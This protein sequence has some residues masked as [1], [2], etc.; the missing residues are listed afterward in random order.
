MREHLLNLFITLIILSSVMGSSVMVLGQDKTGGSSNYDTTTPVGRWKTVDDTTGK[1]KSVV[2]LWEEEGKLYGKIERL[3]NPDPKDPDPRCVRCAGDLKNRHVIGLRIVWDLTQKRDQW[4]GGEI[5][6]PEN[7]KV[8]RCSM[9]VKDRGKKLRVRGFVGFSLL[10][11]T[12][13]WIHDE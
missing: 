1:I 10:G 12:E 11:R 7:G 5:L 2:V 8:Y 4:S 6:D 3:V 13:Y 9:M